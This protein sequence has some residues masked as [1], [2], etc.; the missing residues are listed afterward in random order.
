MGVDRAVLGRY[1]ACQGQVDPGA[2]G[3]HSRNLEGISKQSL[4]NS[5]TAVGYP[6]CKFGVKK[7]QID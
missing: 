3:T 6:W 2:T 1:E 5:A 4:K 7:F